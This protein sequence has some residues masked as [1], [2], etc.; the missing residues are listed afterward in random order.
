MTILHKNSA[1]GTGYLKLAGPTVAWMCYRFFQ[2]D[3]HAS[4]TIFLSP[5][6]SAFKKTLN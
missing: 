5:S 2:V 1:F 4:I 3:Y 6:W